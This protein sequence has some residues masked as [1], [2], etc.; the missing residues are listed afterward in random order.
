MRVV[1]DTNIYVSAIVFGAPCES[2]L[3][4][5]RAQIVGLF[6]SPSILKN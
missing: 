2:I 6:V 1:A 4:L 5:G 3:A